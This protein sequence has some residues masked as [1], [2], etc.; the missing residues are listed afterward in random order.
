[1]QLSSKIHPEE[2]PRSRCIAVVHDTLTQLFDGAARY[3][4]SLQV[5]HRERYSVQRLLSFR[6]YYE[7]TSPTRVIFVCSTSLIPAFVLAV[8]MECIPL[9]PPEAGWRANYAFWIRLFVSSLPI[10]FGAVF[11]VIEVIEPG[12]ISP[13]GIIVTAVGSCAGY[14]ALTMGLA[15]SWRF[16]VPFGYVFCVPPFVTIY[17]ILFVLSIG[18]RV[19]VRTPLLR[20]QLFSQ[21]LV[22]AA[23]AVL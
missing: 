22:V 8:I 5:G 13:T 2:Y 21:L 10:S 12:V 16:P 1:M 6:D 23:Q 19:L 4:N 20:R 3:W 17:M 9:K 14:V 18:P 7:R 11:Q 15:A